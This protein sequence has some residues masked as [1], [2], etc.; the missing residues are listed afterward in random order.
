MI[1]KI[2]LMGRLTAAPELKT[3]TTDKYVTSFNLA[4]E[5]AYDRQQ[6]DFIDIV[7]WGKTAE[8]V[9]RWFGKGDMIALSGRLQTRTWEDRQGNKRKTTEVIT[10]EVSF[11][12]GK[13]EG[14]DKKARD[15]S[16]DFY[17]L[18]DDDDGDLP[19]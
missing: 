4:V 17:E 10:E 19:F 6:A 16:V 11:C 13:S 1:N 3:T 9:C 8:F 12:G 2:V 7:A 5:R 14:V 18:D 15:A